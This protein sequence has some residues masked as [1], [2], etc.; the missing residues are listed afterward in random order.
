LTAAGFLLAT[1]LNPGFV[2][3]IHFAPY[4]EPALAA[5]AMLAALLFVGAQGQLAA[6]GAPAQ[7]WPLAL[8]LAAIVNIKQ[9]GLGLVAA[10]AGAALISAS[11][12]RGVPRMA[13]LRVVGLTLLPATL[14]YAIWRYHVAGAGVAELTPLPFTDWHWSGIGA[15]AAS[16]I[17]VMFG[18]LTYFGCV[19]VALLMLPLLLSRQGWTTTT[20]L[21]MFNA[22]SFLLY[23]I[24]IF[25]T[26]IAA[27]PTEMSIEAHS[28]FRYNTHLSLVLVL[29]LALAARDLGAAVRLRRGWAPLTSAA[30]LA[31]A[32]LAP[33]AF[34]KRL[35]FDLD[36]PQPLVW[37]LAK[38]LSDYLKDGDR[39][40]LLLPGDN[41]SVATMMAG[42]LA[43]TPPRRVRLDILRRNTADPA[44]LDEAARLG[45]PLAFISCT[46][47][48]WKDLPPSESALLR[49][50][51]N[52]WQLQAVWP[53][54]A[55]AAKPRW[56]HILAWGPLC[57]I[58]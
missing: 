15:T 29:A 30:V 43:D 11:A 16:A 57:R 55:N 7:L 44:T 18:K 21:L 9:T 27:F 19:A 32:A 3:R 50:G 45:Y 36:M 48:G 1:L 40:A 2:P 37:D 5:M 10:L 28:Y 22:A 14:L 33:L 25:M 49:Y 34:V 52:G 47:E 13:A 23:N 24:F 53:Y 20:R 38:K 54:P 51:P 58:P 39:L 42:V 8:V 26:Y 35:R 17:H 4:G 56:Q 41:D 6:G 46:P 31:F 12:E